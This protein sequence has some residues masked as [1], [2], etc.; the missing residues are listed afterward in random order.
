MNNAV[1]LDTHAWAWSLG[2]SGKL[3][4]TAHA[5]LYG[6]EVPA[7]SPVSVYEIVQKVRL[8]K[9]AE[10]ARLVPRL[11]Q[12]VEEQGGQWAD[13]TPEISHLAGTLDWSHRDPFDRLLASTALVNGWRLISA[14]AV[15]DDLTGL[16]RVW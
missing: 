11:I 1:L 4:A 2:D 5:A 9:W 14:D 15:F 10:M 6:D 3:T 13:L 16:R 7:I 12:V 8:G